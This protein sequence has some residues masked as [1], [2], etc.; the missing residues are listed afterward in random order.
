MDDGAMHVADTIRALLKTQRLA[1]LS[2]QSSGQPY[3]SLVAFVAGE[4]LQHLYFATPRT[5]RKFNYLSMDSRVAM[6]VDS[7]SNTESDIHEALAVT[8]VGTAIEARDEDK[9]EGISLYL[10]KHPYL[11]DFIRAESCALIR[12]RVK[13]YYLVTRFQQVIELHVS[14]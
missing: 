4:D 7:R 10:S 9:E 13:T 5:T 12:M 2:T 1:V 3:A 11:Q 8:A 14:P 6:L